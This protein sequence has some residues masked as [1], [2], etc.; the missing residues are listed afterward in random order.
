MK[1]KKTYENLTL[2]GESI[3]NKDGSILI[4]ANLKGKV[5]VECV[6]CLQEFE[7]EI[8]ENVKFKIVKPPYDGFDEEY[9]IIEQEVYNLEEILKSEVESIKNDYNICESCE[10]QDFNKEF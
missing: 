8:N 1:V 7:K 3:K 5:L 4:N 9:D 2:E 10:T 6:K